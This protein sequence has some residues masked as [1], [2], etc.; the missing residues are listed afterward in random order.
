MQQGDHEG[1]PYNYQ[2]NNR[3]CLWWTMLHQ[4]E[5]S[6]IIMVDSVLHRNECSKIIMVDAVLHQ[7]EYSNFIMVDAML[8]RNECSK[9]IMV[10]V[11]ATLVVALFHP[12]VVQ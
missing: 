10:A 12:N 6:K 9:I 2:K 4:N 5:Y 8:H 11:G 7:N 1:R 3:K